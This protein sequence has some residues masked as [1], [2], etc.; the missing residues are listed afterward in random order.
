MLNGEFLD[1]LNKEFV[2]KYKEVF[3]ERDSL[4]EQKDVTIYFVF[5]PIEYIIYNSYYISD[6]HF[7]KRH[8]IKH[9]EQ[10]ELF[11]VLAQ[12]IQLV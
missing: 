5:E 1:G 12:L 11:L 6:F 4:E 3:I 8:V 10:S 9:Y 7:T 2:A